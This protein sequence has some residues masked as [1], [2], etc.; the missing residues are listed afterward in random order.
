MGAPSSIG[1]DDDLTTSQTS[2]TLR[3]TN[4]EATRGLDL[5]FVRQESFQED[6]TRSTYV[7]DCPLI[8][9]IGRDHFLDDLLKNF[10]AKV[11]GRDLF[12]VLGGDDNSVDT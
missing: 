7:I 8:K 1:I 10:P 4:D 5:V 6:K 12:R 3:T 11:W 2:I 9:Q